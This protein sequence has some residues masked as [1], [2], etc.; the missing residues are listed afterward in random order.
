LPEESERAR[1][2]A[3]VW[4]AELPRADDVDFAALARIRLAGG[5]IKNVVMAGAHLAAPER[6]PVRLDDL[7]HGIR[8]EYQKLGKQVAAG[9]IRSS[10][11]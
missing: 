4:P 6:R 10:V 2:W 5:N 9:D 1:I 3:A 7:V 8:R 11:A